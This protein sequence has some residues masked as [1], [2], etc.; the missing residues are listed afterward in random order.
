MNKKK[1]K[2]DRLDTINEESDEE[3]TIDRINKIEE[4]YSQIITDRSKLPRIEKK[5][6]KKFKIVQHEIIEED[7]KVTGKNSEVLLKK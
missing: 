4:D 3:H 2:K 7:S 6:N 5:K 1:G